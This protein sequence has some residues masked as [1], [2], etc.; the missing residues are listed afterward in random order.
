MRT[1]G[2]SLGGV[3]ISAH[4]PQ[5]QKLPDEYDRMLSKIERI[6]TGKA[7][8]Q[9]RKL[10]APVEPLALDTPTKIIRQERYTYRDYGA[11]KEMKQQA[12]RLESMRIKE[13]TQR[14]KNNARKQYNASASKLRG[15]IGAAIDAAK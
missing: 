14:T 11:L 5:F 7:P 15:A 12:D 2:L 9:T 1:G 10:N 13:S 4:R 6:Y 3:P 8:L